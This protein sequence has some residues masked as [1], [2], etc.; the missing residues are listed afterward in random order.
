M[1]KSFT[2]FY[3]WQSDKKNSSNYI[4]NAIE[5]AIKLVNSKLSNDISLE[6]NFDRDTRNS[7]G[8]PQIAQTIFDKISQ[9]DIFVCDISLIN[10]TLINKTLKRRLTSN[11]NVLI[12]LGFAINR[13]GWE[14][15]ICVN[16]TEFGA[17]ELLPFDIRGH[18]ITSFN[19]KDKSSRKTLVNNLEIAIRTIIEDYENITDRH[20]L[21]ELKQKDRLVFNK[22][23]EILSEK[24][25][26]DNLNT[27]VTNLYYNNYMH[28]RWVDLIDFYNESI[29]HFI[30]KG[31][32][33]KMRELVN[34]L[35]SFKS[36]C[37]ADINMPNDIGNL[38]LMD[39]KES[40]LEITEEM[41][42]DALQNER[43]FICKEPYKTE[44]WDDCHK[45][46]DHVA[47]KLNSQKEKILSLY[48]ELI[49]IYKKD[50]LP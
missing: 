15:V 36:M 31:L 9:S 23:D 11:P 25:L 16:N 33:E 50:I 47:A 39:L 42:I 37:Y 13:L 22:T 21:D 40:G 46:M 30:H 44:S 3:S 49:Q 20:K 45:R 4:S 29:N 34:E 5:K 41:R 35:N 1:S 43:Y 38:T 7:S 26:I 12:E 18:R 6:I 48:K 8:S 28:S 10:N 2:I 32:D 27:V 24:Y 14:R 19:N 17:N